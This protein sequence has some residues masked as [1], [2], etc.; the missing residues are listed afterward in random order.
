[1]EKAKHLKTFLK[2]MD[3]LVFDV[4]PLGALK[5]G[6][7]ENNNIF[8]MS[9][10]WMNT[11]LFPKKYLNQNSS[12]CIYLE[13]YGVNEIC[14][15]FDNGCLGKIIG[16]DSSM[17]TKIESVE[18]Y[19]YNDGFF[20]DEKNHSKFE[21]F[22]SPSTILGEFEIN[23]LRIKKIDSNHFIMY[24]YFN[25]ILGERHRQVFTRPIL[26]TLD[27]VMECLDT[28]YKRQ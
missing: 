15:Y 8:L 22:L 16:F 6:L 11:I 3:S 7:I 9:I 23:M 26:I 25:D 28:I 13:G 5:D 4:L 1:M 12:V 17:E 24:N 20:I 2:D 10:G 18:H 19:M 27:V 14:R 21:V